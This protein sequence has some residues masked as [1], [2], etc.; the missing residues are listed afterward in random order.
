MKIGNNLLNVNQMLFC[1][2]SFKYSSYL[3][4]FDLLCICLKMYCNLHSSIFGHR[5]LSE[6]CFVIFLAKL[7][8]N[9][10]FR[11]SLSA[12]LSCFGLVP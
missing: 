7:P 4:F 5:F 9:Y 12:V 3:T 8:R 1:I 10:E 6:I 2:F 11:Y